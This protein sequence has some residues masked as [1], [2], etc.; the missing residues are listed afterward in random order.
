M[1]RSIFK[2]TIQVT[3][4]MVIVY[5]FGY[6]LFEIAETGWKICIDSV[7][8]IPSMISLLTKL[9]NCIG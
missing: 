7:Y 8:E 5:V 1:K 3:T 4:A 9:T 2:Q 6:M